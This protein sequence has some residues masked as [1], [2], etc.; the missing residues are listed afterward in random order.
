L[1]EKSHGEKLKKYF[2]QDD[3][4][5]F[6]CEHDLGYW[7]KFESSLKYR[8]EGNIFQ[9]LALFLM[10]KYCGVKANIKEVKK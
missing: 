7:S 3:K 4:E 6:W 5:Q 9:I 8:F 1:F 10:M 2:I